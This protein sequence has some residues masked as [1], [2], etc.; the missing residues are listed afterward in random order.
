MT[1]KEHTLPE[2]RNADRERTS[3]SAFQEHQTR[4]RRNRQRQPDQSKGSEE[5]KTRG[6]FYKRNKAATQQQ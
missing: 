3:I 6:S 5:R 2:Q 4:T 1:R